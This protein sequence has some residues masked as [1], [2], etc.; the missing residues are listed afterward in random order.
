MK[1]SPVKITVWSCDM[2]GDADKCGERHCGLTV[3]SQKKNMKNVMPRQGGKVN[4]LARSVTQCNEACDKRLARLFQINDTTH[5]QQ[6][7]YV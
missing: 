6:S 3:C 5:F 2:E 7:C 1:T 4:N